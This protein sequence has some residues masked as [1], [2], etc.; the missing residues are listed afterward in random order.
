MCSENYPDWL[1]PLFIDNR[2]G[3]PEKKRPA[4][5]VDLICG[6]PWFMIKSD[7]VIERV[8]SMKDYLSDYP[9][10]EKNREAT[11]QNVE[12]FCAYMKVKNLELQN[13]F[14]EL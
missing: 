1:I 3:A 11:S 7:Y 10:Y 2:I 4:A 6:T 12:R 8:D 5:T 14:K 13:A 9:Q